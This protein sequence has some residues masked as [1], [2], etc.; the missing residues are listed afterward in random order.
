M[1]TIVVCVSSGIAAFKVLELVRNLRKKKFGVIVLMSKNAQKM[2]PA[3]EFERAS[4]NTVAI[5]L[6]DKNFNYKKVLKKRSVDHI[7]LAD[8][9]DVIVVA[10]ATANTIAKI[11]GG[12][13]D[14]LLTT[15]L[16]ASK[17]PVLICPSMNCHMWEN[18]KT[19]LNIKSLK[20]KGTFF[21]DPEKGDLACGYEGVGRLAHIDFIEKEVL[22]LAAKGEELKG[23]RVLV[24]AGGTEEK[25]DE[26]RVITN[27]SSGKM[28]IRIA[29]ECVK[30]G[31]KVTLV[32]ARTDIEPTVDV[33]D[34]T[35][36][37]ANDMLLQI[38]KRIK[39][40]D[41]MVHAAAVSDYAVK[42]RQQ[43]KISSSKEL[44]LEL[45]PNTKILEKIKEL[46]KNIFLV[47]FKAEHLLRESELRK[48]AVKAMK[49]A[50]ADMMVA[51]DIGKHCFGS[52]SSEVLILHKNGEDKKIR[53]S[54]KRILAQGIV[55]EVVTRNTKK[56]SS[57]F[58]P[59]NVS[60]FFSI[61][62]NRTFSSKGSLGA[63]FTLDRGVT[64]T[65]QKASKNEILVRG[66]KSAF[67]TVLSV[68]KKLGCDPVTVEIRNGFP[69]GCGFGMSGA[70][71]LAAAYAINDLFDLRKTK[72][73]LALIAHESEVENGTGL[74]DVGGQFNGGIM[75]KTRK[76]K[77][78]DVQTFPVQQEELYYKV[79]G[80][81]ETKTVITDKEKMNQIN[82]AGTKALRSALK[83]KGS[84]ESLMKIA[85]AFAVESKLLRSK[86]ILGVVS[87][88]EKKGGFASMIMLGEAVMST[89]PFRGSKRATISS[90]GAHVL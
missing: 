55:D 71:A 88:V 77:P 15:T 65:V 72:K 35:V 22:T 89:I 32:R 62:G 51:N 82:R 80:E 84:L 39:S 58:A 66:K 74:G 76:G 83:S 18:E 50:K 70:S 86:K 87:S 36:S 61:Y 4:G 24:T 73:E 47:G 33:L 54:D 7:S 85:H 90:R 64:V 29:E 56:K 43:G 49:K 34:I 48:R 53:K 30:R 38:K 2:I 59:A 31:A 5:E 46:N 19:Q 79:F 52:D 68:V 17:A 16:L 81:I 27:K 57:A 78:L 1:Q 8:K 28:G 26:V 40:Q 11:A 69:F 63:G 21:V 6:F 67:P 14:D 37:S 60:C 23:K 44:S 9:A 45:S 75:L 41:I 42:N 10:P 20:R 3:K 25:I 12:V 13:A